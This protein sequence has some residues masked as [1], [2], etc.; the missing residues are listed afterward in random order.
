VDVVVRIEEGKVAGRSIDGPMLPTSS[1]ERMLCDC[2]AHRVLIDSASAI[3]D[4]GR[5]SR[6]TPVDLFNALVLRDQTCRWLG[7]DRPADWCDAHHVVPWWD[8][9]HTRL[10]NL[11]LLCRRHHQ[12][13][14]QPGWTNELRADGTYAVTD[15]R[16]RTYMTHP[17]GLLR[18]LAA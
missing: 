16:G 15:P 7:C 13:G 2:A 17:P 11:V 10:D 1:V 9:G 8:F 3:L 6:T 14:H 12:L 5:A 18:G 4:Y